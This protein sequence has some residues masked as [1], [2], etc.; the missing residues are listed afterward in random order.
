MFRLSPVRA[1]M[2]TGGPTPRKKLEPLT[3]DKPG[4]KKPTRIV[5]HFAIIVPYDIPRTTPWQ[6]LTLNA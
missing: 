3:E 5:Y 2:R 4:E 1:G 6:N